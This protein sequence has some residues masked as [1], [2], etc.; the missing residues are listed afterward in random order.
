MLGEEEKGANG[1]KFS[2][3]TSSG[4]S[5][6]H[7]LKRTLSSPLLCV[8]RTRN[9]EIQVQ[10]FQREAYRVPLCLSLSFSLTGL[11]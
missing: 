6:C 8:V 3:E 4:F 2:M 7:T 11:L 9:R 5:T 10:I 1:S